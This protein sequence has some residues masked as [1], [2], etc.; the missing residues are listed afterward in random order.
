MKLPT[1]FFTLNACNQFWMM[2]TMEESSKPNTD[3]DLKAIMNMPMILTIDSAVSVEIKHS[4]P[5]VHLNMLTKYDDTAL[6]DTQPWNNL[7]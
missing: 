7:K 1:D 3:Y 4:L 6:S 2:M 5:C